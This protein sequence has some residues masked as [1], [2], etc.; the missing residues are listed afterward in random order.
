MNKV[1]ET[2]GQVEAEATKHKADEEK[3]AESVPEKVA[4]VEESEKKKESKTEETKA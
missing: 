2:T 4:K 1:D 3:P